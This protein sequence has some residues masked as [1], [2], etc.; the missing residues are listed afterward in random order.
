MMTFLLL[1]MWSEY[2]PH[3]PATGLL[4]RDDGYV[5]YGVPHVLQLR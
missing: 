5:V 4:H 1:T 3:A 2:Q